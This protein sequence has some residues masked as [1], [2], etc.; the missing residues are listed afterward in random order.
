MVFLFTIIGY[1]YKIY[2]YMIIAY[3][4]MSWVPNMR[5][6]AVG[7]LLGKAV[8]PYLNIF[9]R[10]IPPIGGMIDISPIV[11]LLALYYIYEGL[12]T[13]LTFILQATIGG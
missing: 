13:V 7:E 4:L 2:Y 9:R 10:F 1:A 12:F 6:S 11:A 3:I 5:E 8:D